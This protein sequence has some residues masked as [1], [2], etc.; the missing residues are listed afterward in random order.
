MAR[1]SKKTLEKQIENR[2]SAAYSR[3]CSGV[4]VDIMDLGKISNV[5]RKAIAEGCDDKQLGDRIA[6][7]VETIR[8][9]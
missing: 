5:G 7:F 8:K 3:T 2:I 1:I 6:A 4:Q 9:N